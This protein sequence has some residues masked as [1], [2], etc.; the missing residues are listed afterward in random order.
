MKTKLRCIVLT[1]LLAVMVVLLGV[2]AGV[3]A[4]GWPPPP[5]LNDIATDNTFHLATFRV[6]DLPDEGSIFG[7]LF[8]FSHN[9]PGEE[10]NPPVPG[11]SDSGVIG[12]GTWESSNTATHDR[13][14][15]LSGSFVIDKHWGPGP[16]TLPYGGQIF[17]SFTAQSAY[18]PPYEGEQEEEGTCGN[19]NFRGSFKITGGT[20]YYTGIR[21]AGNIAGTFQA[22]D[23]DGDETVE[24]AVEFVMMGKAFVS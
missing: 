2:S 7:N 20:D 13:V 3:Y 23:Y 21:G 5:P 12:A 15:K 17:V 14:G 4:N 6:I 16:E 24:Q 9:I 1:V 19:Y 18:V 11:V 10:G 8:S 22:H